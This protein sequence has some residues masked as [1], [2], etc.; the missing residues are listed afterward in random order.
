MNSKDSVEKRIMPG[1]HCFAW[2]ADG[3]QVAICPLNNEIWIFET[4]GSPDISKWK[5]IHTLKEH[6]NRVMSLDWHPTTNLLLS[7]SADRGIIVW[8]P[9][10]TGFLPQIGMN[11]EKK[12]HLDAS[13]NHR[14]DKFCVGSS[15]GILY[16]GQFYQNNNFWV[17][18]SI[19]KRPPHKASV[20]CTKFDPLSG[21]VIVSASLDGTIQ[22]HSAY[23]EELDKDS[24]GPFGNV[25]ST[26]E[27]LQTIQCNG[28]V[29]Y[30]NFSPNSELIC[31]V[32]HD[33]ELN[34][35]N[36]SS[37]ASGEKSKLETKKIF[38]HGNPHMSCLFIDD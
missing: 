30:I 21:R 17:A 10:A 14:G 25:T 27:T 32:T 24:A 29:N 6:Y 11:P 28:W 15:S 20:I 18:K 34:F 1:I 8:Q 9:T 22:I 23:V 35:T 13:W 16:L 2:R 7:A 19:K 12:A 33:C 36:V 5:Q 4:G 26:G 31:Y 3:Q 37:A 38:H